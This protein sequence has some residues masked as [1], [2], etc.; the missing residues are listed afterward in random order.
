[1][2]FR[3]LQ[4]F[5]IVPSSLGV[6]AKTRAKVFAG[7]TNISNVS[8]FSACNHTRPD[9]VPFPRGRIFQR[10]SMVS[11]RTRTRARP[12]A[13]VSPCVP[14]ATAV[15]SLPPPATGVRQTKARCRWRSGAAI[16]S[17]PA[18]AI[19]WSGRGGLVG[20]GL[21]SLHPVGTCARYIRCDQLISTKSFGQPR[22]AANVRATH[23]ATR[24][25]IIA[26]HGPWAWV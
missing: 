6:T 22:N 3:S 18:F 21:S 16:T 17:R 12:N 20:C 19:W 8:K 24:R 23:G 10:S 2:P 5:P 4:R 14:R 13:M 11:C 26:T 15:P 9:R 25:P 7:G 1:M